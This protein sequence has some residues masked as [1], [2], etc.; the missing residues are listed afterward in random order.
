MKLVLNCANFKR[1]NASRCGTLRKPSHSLFLFFSPSQWMTS[2][3]L[4]DNPLVVFVDNDDDL[5]Y[6][7]SLRRDKTCFVLVRRSLM[8]SF[9]EETRQRVTNITRRPGYFK[10]YP[11][12]V[13]TDYSLVQNA[14]YEV[15]L[16]CIV[17]WLASRHV[18]IIYIS[19][20]I[21]DLQLSA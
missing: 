19:L 7:R 4:I 10:K 20:R 13:I 18:L 14:K 21:S 1:C 5:S 12:T 3:A 9:S 17:K 11:N 16:A 2:F 6:F 8:C 15:M